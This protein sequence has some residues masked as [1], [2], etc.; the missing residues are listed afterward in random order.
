MT[1]IAIKFHEAFA[2]PVSPWKW[3]AMHELMLTLA[4]RWDAPG[5]VTP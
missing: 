5:M 3:E 2:E 4:M 1:T